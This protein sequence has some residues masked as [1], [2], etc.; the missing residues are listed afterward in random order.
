M[1]P[2]GDALMKELYPLFNAAESEVVA[3]LSDRSLKGLTQSLRS[4]VTD[5][6]ARE[7][8]DTP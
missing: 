2:A 5:L 1:T 4:I 3:G 8:I 6:E 7:S